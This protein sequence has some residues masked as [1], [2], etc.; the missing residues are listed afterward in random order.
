[1][2]F[3]GPLLGTKMSPAKGFRRDDFF[4][5]TILPPMY[6]CMGQHCFSSRRPMVKHIFGHRFSSS[7][8]DDA[9][10]MCGCVHLMSNQHVTTTTGYDC[11]YVTNLMERT[12]INQTYFTQMAPAGKKQHALSGPGPFFPAIALDLCTGPFFPAIPAIA[13]CVCVCVY[14]R[15]HVCMYVRTCIDS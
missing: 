14:I 9:A 1:M 15:V 10:T 11:S 7:R 2:P 13:L 3:P 12:E 6:K 5:F 8:F 4:G